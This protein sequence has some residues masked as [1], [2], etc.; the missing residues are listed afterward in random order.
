MIE[1]TKDIACNSNPTLTVH[2]DWTLDNGHLK[3]ML[4]RYYPIINKHYIN[5]A[6][7]WFE[8]EDEPCTYCQKYDASKH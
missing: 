3:E 2:V 1:V 8:L 4:H 5:K 6:G 7:K